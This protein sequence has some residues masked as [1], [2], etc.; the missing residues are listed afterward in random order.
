[1]RVVLTGASGQLGAY[2]VE[3]LVAR[4]HQ[5]T[6][7]SGSSHGERS[8]IPLVPVDLTD[9]SATEPALSAVDPDVVVHVAAI[10]AAEAV[11]R[12]PERGEAVNVVATERLAQ[13]CAR[14][15]R[16]LVYTS[17]DL[18]F[19]GSKAWNR[20]DDPAEPVIAYGRTKR[21]AEASVL[22]VPSGLVAR[23]SLLFGP[24]RC[25]R[26]SFFSRMIDALKLGQPQALFVDEF[27][28]PLHLATA[29]TLLVRLAESPI[30]G[31]IHVAGTER[32]SRF[33]LMRRTAAA[34]GLDLALVLPNSRADVTGPDPR[35][36][37]VSL[38]TSRLAALLPNVRRPSIEEGLAAL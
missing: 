6:A 35:P 13:W 5:V 26:P 25:G 2:L 24:S 32:L 38:D 34:L 19:D 37:D 9:P 1:M 28:T 20:E 18:V 10:S 23:A 7:W 22:E 29:A 12:D 30:T 15:G 11:R 27:R 33:E 36:A 14:R 31:L 3:E 17:T 21:A 8:G 16:R 4:G